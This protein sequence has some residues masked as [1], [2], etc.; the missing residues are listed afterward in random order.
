MNTD[1]SFVCPVTL[2]DVYVFLFNITFDYFLSP[3]YGDNDITSIR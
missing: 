3:I 2:V 1:Y